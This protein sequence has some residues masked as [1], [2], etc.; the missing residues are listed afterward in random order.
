VLDLRRLVAHAAI[1]FV[2]WAVSVVAPG[3]AVA[4]DRWIPSGVH[5]RVLRLSLAQYRRLRGR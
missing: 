1:V 3:A 4:R 2:V 5:L